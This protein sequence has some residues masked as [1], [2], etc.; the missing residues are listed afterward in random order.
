M[1]LI[2]QKFIP[3]LVPRGPGIYLVGGCVRDLLLGRQTNDFDLAV[4]GDA[5]SFALGMASAAGRRAVAMGQGDK[6]VYRIAAGYESYD[7]SGIKG[8]DIVSDLLSR[9]FTVNAMAVNTANRELIDPSGGR[10]DLKERLLRMVCPEAFDSDPLRLLRAFRIAGSLEFRLDAETLE[11]ISRRSGKIVQTPGERIREEWLRML[12][13]RHSAKMIDLAER[14]GLLGSM[15]PEINS[16]K[17]CAQ[18][19]HHRFDVFDHTMDVYK[20]AELMLHEN[21]PRLVS[22]R[23]NMSLSTFA[24]RP[25]IVK[26]AALFHDIGK[27][28]TLSIDEKGDIHFYNHDSEGAKMIH[29]I[30]RRLRF[31]NP[32]DRYTFFL[33]KNHLSPLF[34]YII[35]KRGK[36]RPETVARFFLRTAPLT[37]DLLMLAAADKSGKQKGGANGFMDFIKTIL[38]HYITSH[39]PAMQ[40]TRL[41][42]GHDLIEEFGLEPSPVFS[43]ILAR[44][45]EMRLAGLLKNRE[46]AIGFTAELLKKYTDK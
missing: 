6:R 30:N 4:K 24:G 3:E 36:L 12:K 7:I 28:A 23:K 29:E 31:S 22:D 8:P 13:N 27:P 10:T 19:G 33:V 35:Y 43:K 16:L 9:D 46:Q 20:A 42:T 45:E 37:P 32:E 38:H 34:L 11:A 18:G 1:T 21:R 39:L 25:E 40:R 44:V 15:F 26:H 17:G 14:T 5:E 2:N 41:I